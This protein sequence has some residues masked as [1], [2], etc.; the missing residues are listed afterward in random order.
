MKKNNSLNLVLALTL[1]STFYNI[2]AAGA[3]INAAA[4]LVNGA[5]YTSPSN[6]N[7]Y[8][9]WANSAKENPAGVFEIPNEGNNG[10]FIEFYAEAKIDG[11]RAPVNDVN[12]ALSIVKTVPTGK[13]YSALTQKQWAQ[14]ILDSWDG[15]KS[16]LRSYDTGAKM[17]E[18]LAITGETAGFPRESGDL[19]CTGC[20]FRISIDPIRNSQGLLTG[21]TISVQIKG[22]RDKGFRYLYD[23]SNSFNYTLP[24]IVSGQLPFRYI[25][26]SNYQRDIIYTNIKITTKTAVAEKLAAEEAAQQLADDAMKLRSLLLGGI[27][28]NTIGMIPKAEKLYRTHAEWIQ[29]NAPDSADLNNKLDEIKQQIV[30]LREI[31]GKSYRINSRNDLIAAQEDA[32]NAD[33]QVQKLDDECSTLEVN[34]NPSQLNNV[35]T[36]P[37]KRP[38]SKPRTRQFRG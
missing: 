20:F 3:L 35:S 30:F 15:K 23:S 33:K 32:T 10:A 9:P 28:Q 4:T 6:K 36:N 29:K 17:T 18:H 31:I 8:F 19:P 27:E 14:L 24:T 34:Y 7:G 22:K 1:A 11:H 25:L 16:V 21:N 38:T 2:S 26:L 37:S 12:V 5:S 13:V